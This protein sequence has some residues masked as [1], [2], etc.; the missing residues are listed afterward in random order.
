MD[1]YGQDPQRAL[2]LVD[3]AEIVGN[4][5]ASR[6]DLMR[7][8]VMSETLEGNRL[9]SAIVLG[10]RLLLSQEA[11]SDKAF[12]QD[13]LE[14]LVSA[15]RRKENFELYMRTSAELASLCREQG[16]TTEA[17]R[18]EAEVGLALTNLGQREKGLAKINGVLQALAG[19]RHFNELDAYIVAA[20]RKYYILN[21]DGRYAEAIDP[22]EQIIEALDDYEQHPSDYHDD[23]YREPSD[24]DR[25]GYIDFYRMQA[26]GLLANIHA[27]LNDKTA[28]RHYL[29]LYNQ[30]PF[31]KTFDSRKSIAPTL[32][33]LGDYA[34]ME[35]I[36]KDVERHLANDTV[37]AYYATM[38]QN[39]AQAALAQ[40]RTAE[41]FRL[42]E[43]YDVVQDSIHKR[44]LV[45]KAHDYAARFQAQQL[46]HEIEVQRE[47]SKTAIA[48]CVAIAIFL[49]AA[50]A[51]AVALHHRN[52]VIRQKN[53]ILA[54]QIEEM[55]KHKT[56]GDGVETGIVSMENGQWEMDN[57]AAEDAG[58]DSP[59]TL[60]RQLSQ[61][62]VDER[63]FLDPAF[64]RQAAME[65]F[66]LSKERIGTAFA[67][68]SDY[69]SLASFVTACRVEYGARLLLEQPE[70][71][72]VQVATA[73]GFSSVNHFGRSFKATYGLSPT[74]FRRQRE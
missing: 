34:A 63:L 49:L 24:E 66:H 33:L 21:D 4:L 6:A 16:L 41:A 55:M 35:A 1:I 7:I 12:R 44:I 43:R 9:D 50:I 54:R 40:G 53:R 56:S 5:S 13:V 39:R 68:G 48:V 64:D 57:E 11:T 29:E 38:L 31:A 61:A 70:L 22:C 8:K 69:A 30:S 26:Y 59:A 15:S 65:R 2:L 71:T 10:E 74:E 20:K 47:R 52:R 46:Q 17:L 51:I 14:S 28:A 62:I 73:S 58:E 19:K 18:N 60:F 25:P 3:S 42:R 37:N 45:S 36:Y 27:H 67:Q 23:T 72:V 32:C